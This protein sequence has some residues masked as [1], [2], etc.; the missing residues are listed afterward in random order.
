MVAKIEVHVP[1]GCGR[2]GGGLA[3]YGAHLNAAGARM[4][5]RCVGVLVSWGATGVHSCFAFF[6]RLLHTQEPSAPI[7]EYDSD[8]DG[9]M[10]WRMADKGDRGGGYRPRDEG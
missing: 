5:S 4:V 10:R 6:S 9:D 7:E 8:L 1:V 3:W 2:L